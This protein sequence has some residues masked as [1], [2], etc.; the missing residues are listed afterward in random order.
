MLYRVFID[1][2]A[3]E[4]KED[5]VAAGAIIGAHG[6]WAKIRQDWNRRLHRDGL[7][8]FRSTEYYS[9][10]GEFYRFR[11]RIK[12]PKPKGGEAA[13]ALRNDL[14]AILQKSPVIG[15]GMII[16]MGIYTEFR[17][18]MPL[19]DQKISSD[20]YESAV[21]TLMFECGHVVRDKIPPDR[22]KVNR[23]A[24]VCDD[25]PNAARYSAVYAGFKERNPRMASILGG[26]V[27]LDDKLHPP[28]QAADMMAS[29]SK[30]LFLNHMNNG[31]VDLKTGRLLGEKKKYL[32]SVVLPRLNGVTYNIHVWDW[33]WMMNVLE[34]QD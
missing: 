9:L 22:G 12:Y 8:Y 4:K 32:P 5:V 34:A 20:P 24:F 15:V 6:V 31:A 26:M 2:S 23:L 13:L 14:D 17:A 11:D 33:P 28:L 16:P 1:D 25:T 27:H 29:L 7:R 18:T 21:Q 10:T 30:E 19:A 3:D